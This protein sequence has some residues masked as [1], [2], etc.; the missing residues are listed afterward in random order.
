[1]DGIAGFAPISNFAKI[2]TQNNLNSSD[3]NFLN[4]M[5]EVMS[6]NPLEVSGVS[7]GNLEQLDLL[8]QKEPQYIKKPDENTIEDTMAE[9]EKILSQI[10][11]EKD[12]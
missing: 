11:K 1:M 6:V 12:K 4:S 2:E 3:V 5:L 9:I 7:Q 8:N 10:K